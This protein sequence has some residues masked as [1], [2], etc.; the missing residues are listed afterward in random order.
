MALE[1]ERVTTRFGCSLSHATLG[2]RNDG[3]QNS[4]YASSTSTAV[5]AGTSERKRLRRAGVT[6]VPV[7]LLGLPTTTSRVSA[8]TARSIAS[9]STSKPAIGALRT[10]A[11]RTWG[12]LQ[13]SGK[14][15]AGQRGRAPGSR[16]ARQT[17]KNRSSDPQPT[18]TDARSAPV[19]A[20]IASRSSGASSRGERFESAAAPAI[21]SRTRGRG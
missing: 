6:T 5:D 21:A 18:A 7:G 13:Y 15:R 14:E 2:G 8:S 16:S 4:T 1:K 19:E 12:I 17:W 10:S 11:R 3:S 9:R 20:A